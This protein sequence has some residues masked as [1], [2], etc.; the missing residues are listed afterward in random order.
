VRSRIASLFPFISVHWKQE[1]QS[2]IVPLMY[3][4]WAELCLMQAMRLTANLHVTAESHHLVSPPTGTHFGASISSTYAL[5]YMVSHEE[6][7]IFWE[8]TVSVIRSKRKVYMYMCPVPNGFRD[9]ANF[10]VEYTVQ[11]SNTPCSHTS[12]KAH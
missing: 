1:S 11:T 7:P 9:R 12:C 5:L 4:K 10:T 2:L 8:V 3:F 6:R